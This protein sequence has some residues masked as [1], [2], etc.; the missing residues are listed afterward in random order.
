MH[1]RPNN[2]TFQSEVSAWTWAMRLG[3]VTGWLALA[4]YLVIVRWTR[5][6]RNRNGN[7]EYSIR[8][9]YIAESRTS[10]PSG[11]TEQSSSKLNTTMDNS[12]LERSSSSNNEFSLL[13]FAF[14]ATFSVLWLSWLHGM[15]SIRFTIH[16]TPRKQSKIIRKY[17]HIQRLFR[18][19]FKMWHTYDFPCLANPSP[20]TFSYRLQ[21]RSD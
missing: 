21:H 7:N 13:D 19:L 18:T 8:F 10:S 3:R 11:T 12:K 17:W 4:G 6:L 2:N 9:D 14:F 1:F 5:S 16:I 20:D 15:P